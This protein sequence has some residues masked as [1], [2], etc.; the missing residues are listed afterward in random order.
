M[1]NRGVKVQLFGPWK[2]VVSSKC[3]TRILQLK[4]LEDYNG[5]P[6]VAV[7]LTADGA[8]YEEGA[9]FHSTLERMRIF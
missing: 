4:M 6:G 3:P 1:E 8:G 9:G 5:D 2:T 7:L